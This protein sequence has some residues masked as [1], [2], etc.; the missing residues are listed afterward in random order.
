MRFHPAT[1][2]YSEYTGQAC[3]VAH[4]F[5]APFQGD[6]AAVRFND[7]RVIFAYIPEL[8]PELPA[9]TYD[10]ETDDFLHPTDTGPDYEGDKYGG[11][12]R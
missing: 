1:D 11:P 3:S 7:G 12:V 5:H 9:D 10:P 4:Y 8:S 2:D 6:L